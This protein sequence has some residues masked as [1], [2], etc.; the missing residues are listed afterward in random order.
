MGFENTAE[1][2]GATTRAVDDNPCGLCKNL[3]IPY[4]KGHGSTPDDGSSNANDSGNESEKTYKQ[5]ITEQQ[6]K[7]APTPF[8][9]KPM[10]SFFNEE[11]RK[12]EDKDKD[13]DKEELNNNSQE[14]SFNPSPY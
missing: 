12:Q 1:K 3:G 5:E 4:C 7:T 14:N 8:Q 10:P 6:G 9:S 13:K 11:G 2:K